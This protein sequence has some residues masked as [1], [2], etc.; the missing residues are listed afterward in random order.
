MK[1]HER[2]AGLFLLLV[3]VAV[4][5]HSYFSLGFGS[6]LVPGAGFLPF[7]YGVALAILSAI[8]VLGNRGPEENPV[9]FWDKGQWVR[10]TIAFLAMLAY[11]WL[12][13]K[14]GYVLSTFLFVIA[15]QQLIERERWGK[16]LLISV[17][18]TAAMYIL[19]GRF[20]RVP[21]PQGIFPL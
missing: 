2:I 7:W 10:P 3:G 6:F 21:L 11:G 8:W 20:L 1:R 16:T 18:G 5:V 17:L 12:M 9:P 13:D 15:W 19:F 4:A 14:L